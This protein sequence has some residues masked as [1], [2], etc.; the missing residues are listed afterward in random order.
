[1]ILTTHKEFKG[2]VSASKGVFNFDDCYADFLQD[3]TL[4][5]MKAIQDKFKEE[6][7]SDFFFNH[8]LNDKKNFLRVYTIQGFWSLFFFAAKE[9]D[10]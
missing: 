4:D 5:L 10:L 9:A 6:I 8:H 7:S 2:T 1:M 3:K